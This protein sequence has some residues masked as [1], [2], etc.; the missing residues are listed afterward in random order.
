MSRTDSDAAK[1]APVERSKNGLNLE[2]N[3]V[4]MI[5]GAVFASVL[6]G[7]LTALA[8]NAVLIF[9]IAGVALALLAALVGEATDQVGARLGPGA[10]GVLQSA[11]GNL[12]ELFVGIFALRAGLLDVVQSALVGSILGNSLF[13]L[14]LAFFVGG[15]RHGPQR[16]NS[17]TPRMIA[18]LTMLAVA[19]LA[20]PTLVQGLHTPAAGHEEG[21]SIACAIILLAVFIASIPVSLK[22]GTL[23]VTTGPL[24]AAEA[25]LRDLWPV[26]LAIVVLVGAGVGSA[27]VS[28]W[29]IA[30]LTP[31]I[32]VLHISP[33]FTGLVIV[34][35]A[36]NAVENVVGIQFAARNQP[37]FAISVILNSSL[38]VALGLIPVLVLLSFVIGGVHLTL[39]LPPLLV[40]AL[41]LTAILSTVIIYDGEST[42]LE[43]LAL[44]GLYA[45][46]AVSFWWG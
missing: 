32:T 39:V 20:V 33:A 13:V 37:D 24:K 18:T 9:V 8:A 43:G 36:G 46:I 19:A 16:F 3:Q 14:G 28:D 42:W 44:I 11:L 38:Q 41:G 7:V 35:L 45:I 30:A 4:V 15:L 34:A 40:A 10:T 22:G 25:V 23:A 27:F 6:A 5:A 21:L 12:P 31:A 26:W 29:F 1:T 17:D 2:R